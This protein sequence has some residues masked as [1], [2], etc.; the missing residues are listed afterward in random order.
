M[1]TKSFGCNCGKIIEYF[2]K[3]LNSQSWWLQELAV[4]FSMIWKD[5]DMLLPLSSVSVSKCGP[6]DGLKASW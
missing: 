3:A 1:L 6:G 2:S 5:R 4:Y